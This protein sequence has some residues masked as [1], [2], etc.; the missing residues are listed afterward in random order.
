VTVA[1]ELWAWFGERALGADG[2]RGREGAR[3]LDAPIRGSCFLFVSLH[4]IA[5]FRPAG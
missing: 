1:Q 2:R 4:F 3:A 5:P